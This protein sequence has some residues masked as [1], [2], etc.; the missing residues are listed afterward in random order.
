[1]FDPATLSLRRPDAP[2]GPGSTTWTL[3]AGPRQL[4]GIEGTWQQAYSRGAYLI[5]FLQRRGLHQICNSNPSNPSLIY[6]RN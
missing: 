4:M 5:S 6:F 3:L 2:E 1:M